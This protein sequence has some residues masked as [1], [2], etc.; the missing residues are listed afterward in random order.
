MA[1]VERTLQVAF[2]MDARWLDARVLEPH[3]H[4][5]GAQ[6]GAHGHVHALGEA[7]ELDV[8]QPGDVGAIGES[9]VDRD[10][11]GASTG[12]GQDGPQHFRKADRVLDQRQKQLATVDL[13]ALQSTEGCGE[14]LQAPRDALALD[15]QR[16]AHRDRR[17]R[18]VDVVETG[19]A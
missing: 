13:D 16:R 7:F 6:A 8:P 18:V 17:E 14:R 12:R 5:F 19:Q 11:Q 15:A 3:G 2:D 9:I 4:V 10:Q 1:C